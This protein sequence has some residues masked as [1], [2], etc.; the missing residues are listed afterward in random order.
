M[1]LLNREA[2]FQLILNGLYYFDA[3]D[4]ENT[5]LLLNTVS[6]NR[7][8]FTQREY[9]V[10]REARR[11]MHLL[12]FLSEQDFE[13]IVRL[14]MIINCPVTF[15][16]VKNAE[17]IFGPDITSL[18]VKSVKRKPVS[19]VTDYVEIPGEIP[20]SRKELGVSTYI[21]FINKLPFLAIISQRLK[22]TKVEYLSSKNKIALVNSIN[23]IISY[24]RSHGF[25]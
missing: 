8:G 2:R 3:T 4:R 5:M 21:I 11:A 15:S 23:K 25:M 10:A 22:L 18:K 19:V 1:V 13:N 24:Y 12:G 7:E 9:E 17:L 6:E 20:E 16:D 14:N